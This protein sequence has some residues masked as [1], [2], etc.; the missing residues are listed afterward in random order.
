MSNAEEA[1]GLH[2]WGMEKDNE[3]YITDI[4][5]CIALK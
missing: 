4:I 5:A 2:L 1:L 3:E